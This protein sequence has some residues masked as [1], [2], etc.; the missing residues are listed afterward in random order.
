MP[1]KR[2]RARK[3]CAAA[4]A[5]AAGDGGDWRR[6][7]L[8][9]WAPQ[10]R[11]I[12][13]GGAERDAIT[14]TAAGAL[15]CEVCKAAA[16]KGIIKETKWSKFDVK[17]KFL[18]VEDLKRHCNLAKTQQTG[19]IRCDSNHAKAL[20][21]LKLKHIAANGCF[22]LPP[23][24]G[25]DTSTN[26]ALDTVSVEPVRQAVRTCWGWGGKAVKDYEKQ[27]TIAHTKT[28]DSADRVRAGRHVSARIIL[29][30]SEV[31][32]D[33][34][35]AGANE[36]LLSHVVSSSGPFWAS[37]FRPSSLVQVCPAL[38]LC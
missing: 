4:A 20:D 29:A 14:L 1:A 31:E 21:A 25:A 16:A 36:H 3:A 19:K 8:A 37:L 13:A 15:G 33:V 6:A 30:A 11:Y 2:P 27:G 5:A 24:P 32:F 23:A 38:A 7:A 22:G 10:L 35:P 28:G 9:K 12:S 17:P 34:E 26:E 18:Q